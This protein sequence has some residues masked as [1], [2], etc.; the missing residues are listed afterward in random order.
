MGE[1]MIDSLDLM[2]ANYYQRTFTINQSNF[3]GFFIINILYNILCVCSGCESGRAAV[4]PTPQRVG[5][6]SRAV[7]ENGKIF[8]KKYDFFLPN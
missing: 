3:G 5:G 2:I 4:P 1:A 7:V 6:A 8:F